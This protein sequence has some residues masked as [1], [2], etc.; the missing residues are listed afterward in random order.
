[1]D[2]HVWVERVQDTKDVISV[3]DVYLVSA[4]VR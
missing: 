4:E 3:S 1:M 2:D